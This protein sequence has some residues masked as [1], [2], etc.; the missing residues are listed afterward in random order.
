MSAFHTKDIANSTFLV[1]GGAGFIG[2]HI[3]EYLLK[4]NA[5][6]VK[7]LDN[8]STGSIHNVD[9]FKSYPQYEF[10]E[11][12][13]RNEVVCINACNGVD[14]VSHQAALGSVPRSVK[15]PISTNSVNIDGFIN[16]INAAKNAH[17]KSF[18]Y[19]SSS[20]VYGDEP[21]LPKKESITGNLLSPYAVTKMTNEL[22]ANVFARVYRIKVI[23]L[24]YFNVF[25][26]RQDPNGP[27]AAVI[28]LFVDGILN[29]KPVYINGDGEQTRDFTYVDNAIQANVKGMLTDN[30]TAFGQVYNVAVGANFSVNFLYKAIREMLD[31]IH[32]PI[33]REPREGDIRNSLADITKAKTLLGYLPTQQFLGGLKITVD[34]FKNSI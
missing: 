34:F 10:I 27:Y 4:N 25:G 1:T 11:G 22:Y 2:S 28:P 3:V 29:S 31:K 15:D 14:Y 24:R 30:V 7:V 16:I 6:K 33:F 23:G 12:D 8:L 13:I 5:G 18:V 17:V 21:N 26:P 32:E 9:L 20:S 19:A